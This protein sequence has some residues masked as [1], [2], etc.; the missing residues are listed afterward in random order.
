LVEFVSNLL[1]A[2]D[3]PFS[4]SIAGLWLLIN[5][6]G[7]VFTDIASFGPLLLIM[8]ILGTSL[9][10]IDPFGK[11]IR[12]ILGKLSKY[13]RIK[14]PSPLLKS[15]KKP[16]EIHREETRTLELEREDHIRLAKA[17]RTVWISYEI[18]KL[19]SMI[20]FF[21]I[22]SAIIYYLN[23]PTLPKILCEA[24]IK[25]SN[26]TNA[27]APAVHN[28]DKNS[29]LIPCMK[30]SQNSI[31]LFLAFDLGILVVMYLA[32]RNLFKYVK[33]VAKYFEAVQLLGEIENKL[34]SRVEHP[35][36]EDERNRLDTTKYEHMM[37]GVSDHRTDCNEVLN[38]LN[39]KDWTM[40][41]F[42]LE[43]LERW[44]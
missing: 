20:Y 40:A 42:L 43:K 35:E 39:Q 32:V 13:Q 31:Y 17:S 14:R 19:V 18:D 33:T 30:A 9:S 34:R 11:G 1:K 2:S 22:L 25:S 7:A 21:I 15:Y 10:I 26:A 6:H 37:K 5:G 44:A 24:F 12:F 38:Y 8:G 27:T 41:A 16:D 4:Y 23:T 28:P 36:N 3:Y 29:Q